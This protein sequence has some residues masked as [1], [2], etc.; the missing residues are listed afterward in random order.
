MD[1]MWTLREAKNSSSN[2]S[3]FWTDCFKSK[4]TRSERQHTGKSILKAKPYFMGMWN[5]KSPC[6]EILIAGIKAVYDLFK[7]RWF[8]PS[9]LERHLCAITA[10]CRAVP[11]S[12][13]RA[14]YNHSIGNH[15]DVH[16]LTVA[17]TRVVR[18]SPCCGAERTLPLF[19][20]SGQ[21]TVL[22]FFDLRLEGNWKWPETARLNDR[23][24]AP[25]KRKNF[26]YP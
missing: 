7:T 13:R 3:F 2:E 23:D 24:L 25:G 20:L 11:P 9:T 1:G 14:P 15:L 4:V 17:C 21:L 6:Y 12:V 5:F 26:L 10:E 19:L 16:V 22:C 18:G 8:K